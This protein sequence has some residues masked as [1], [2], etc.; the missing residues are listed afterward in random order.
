MKRVSS[1]L[2]CD[3]CI[4]SLKSD[5]KEG[6]IKLRDCSS[7]LLSPSEFVD[8]ILK[9][10][11]NILTVEFEK[12]SILKNYYFYYINIKICNAF[13]S[14]HG[15]MFV[16]MDNHCYELLKKIVACYCSIRF[17]SHAKEK[18][19]ELKKNESDPS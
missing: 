5:K 3:E 15:K 16:N 9:L 4:Q 12:N 6:L 10:S 14:L 13:I 7:K 2:S 11:E 17:K 1:K 18:N 19:E 8:K